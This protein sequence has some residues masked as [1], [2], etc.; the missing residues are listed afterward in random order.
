MPRR[1]RSSACCPVGT[2]EYTEGYGL[3]RLRELV[4]VEIA[5]STAQ[6][7]THL[8]QSLGTLFRLVN[9][10]YPPETLGPDGVHTRPVRTR[11]SCGSRRCAP[12]SSAAT[13][14]C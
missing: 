3:D 14:P 12:I 2:P 10:G 5:S 6:D 8:Y 7:G 13:P 4:L 11:V 1:A 9:E